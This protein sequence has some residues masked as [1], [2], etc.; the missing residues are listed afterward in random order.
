LASIFGGWFCGWKRWP[1]AGHDRGRV[2]GHF[3]GCDLPKA[4]QLA[5]L[6]L[7]IKTSYALQLAYE[8]YLPCH[9]FYLL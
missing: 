6:C 8:S 9:Y 5:S 3:C 2:I 4:G 1:A 7:P